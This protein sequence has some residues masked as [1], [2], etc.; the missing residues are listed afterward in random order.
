MGTHVPREG[1]PSRQRILRLHRRPPLQHRRTG[2][3]AVRVRPLAG[4]AG[5]P[6]AR[7][8]EAAPNLPGHEE[9][10]GTEGVA[11]RRQQLSGQT[12]TTEEGRNFF[13][14]Q[15]KKNKKLRLL[16]HS[17]LVTNAMAPSSAPFC[18]IFRFVLHIGGWRH[19]RMRRR[20]D[21]LSI[22]NIQSFALSPTPV[23]TMN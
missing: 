5:R 1:V 22:F 21:G 4:H 11:A 20:T 15:I 2:L 12:V 8:N 16:F 9:E 3:P 7:R 19:P 10:E 6:H 18:T 17:P 13:E 23:A 14:A